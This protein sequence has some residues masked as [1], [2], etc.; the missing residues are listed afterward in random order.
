MWKGNDSKLELA[1]VDIY[2]EP[3]AFVYL[4]DSCQL[5]WGLITVF[6]EPGKVEN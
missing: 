5:H 4:N 2:F 3:S 1:Y 6:S